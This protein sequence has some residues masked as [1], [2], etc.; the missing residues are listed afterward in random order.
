MSFPP[1]SFENS[2]YPF[3]SLFLDFC[4]LNAWIRL[5]SSPFPTGRGFLFEFFILCSLP[6]DKELHA[7]LDCSDLTTLQHFSQQHHWH[8]GPDNSGICGNRWGS[9]R[10]RVEG[11]MSGRYPLDATSM[12]PAPSQRH[13]APGW[14]KLTQLRTTA[15][16]VLCSELAY[17]ID[18]APWG[19]CFLSVSQAEK[20]RV[21]SFALTGKHGPGS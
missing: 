17:S 5:P 18:M 8:L 20:Q 3:F 4:F 7:A 14:W 2:R 9:V 15:T 19:F 21:F 1:L 16:L 12:L 13:A 6:L 10:S 11:G